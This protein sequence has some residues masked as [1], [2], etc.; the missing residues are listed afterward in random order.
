MGWAG[1]RQAQRLFD[2]RRG[3][4]HRVRRGRQRERF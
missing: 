4:A 2:V 1:E 3:A